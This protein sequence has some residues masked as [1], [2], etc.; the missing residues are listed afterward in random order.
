MRNVRVITHTVHNYL[1]SEVKD[2][3]YYLKICGEYPVCAIE[4]CFSIMN[5]D[6]S[7]DFKLCVV[8]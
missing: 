7:S 4:K 2:N 3:Q 5:N 1:T 6:Q 8:I